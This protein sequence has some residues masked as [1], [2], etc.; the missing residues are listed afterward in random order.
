MYHLRRQSRICRQVCGGQYHSSRTLS[1]YRNNFN[2]MET[3][4]THSSLIIDFLDIGFDSKAMSDILKKEVDDVLSLIS[5]EMPSGW[6]LIFQANYSNAREVL[7]SKNRHGSYP[8]DK[9][10]YVTIVIPIPLKENIEWGVEEKQ[11]TYGKDHYDKFKKNFWALEVDYAQYTNRQDY[12]IACLRGG[13][14]KAFEEGFTV[15]GV[16]VKCDWR[17]DKS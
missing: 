17:I 2:Y 6:S 4:I 10:K 13:I 11:Y 14:K 15:G 7:I 12:I 3:F 8:S 16:K 1:T 9:L 5:I